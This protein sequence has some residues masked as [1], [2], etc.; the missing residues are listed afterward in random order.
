MLCALAVA[1]PD[2]LFSQELRGFAK[3][4]HQVG[5]STAAEPFCAVTYLF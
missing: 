4:A 3:R 2:A 5:N 1:G